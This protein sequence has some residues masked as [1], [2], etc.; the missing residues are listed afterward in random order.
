MSMEGQENPGA[1]GAPEA[2][3]TPSGALVPVE[4]VMRHP[5]V[6]QMA[7]RLEAV[8]SMLHALPEAIGRAVAQAMR[9]PP[10]GASGPPVP[11]FVPGHPTFPKELEFRQGGKIVQDGKEFQLEKKNL[12]PPR[13]AK[14][15][16]KP[17][18]P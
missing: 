17:L 13:E 10:T 7:Q 5:V 4:Q 14:L 15:K 2:P 18:T 1:E 3:G 8:E 9:K 16:T 11:L 12:K 6:V